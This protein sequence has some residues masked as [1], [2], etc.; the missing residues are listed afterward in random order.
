M[1]DRNLPWCT[2]EMDHSKLHLTGEMN[3]QAKKSCTNQRKIPTRTGSDILR[4]G[5]S[6][7]GNFLVKE[8]YY[9]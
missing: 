6:K 3:L 2:W 9:L 7:T 1:P 5:H 4:W 8:A